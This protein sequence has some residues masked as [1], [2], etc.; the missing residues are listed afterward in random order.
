[1]ASAMVDL[2]QPVSPA[3]PRASP[4]ATSKETSST[5]RRGPEGVW[6]ETDRFRTERSGGSTALPPSLTAVFV[7]GASAR[8]LGSGPGL[9]LEEL[10]PEESGRSAKFLLDPEEL[11]VFCYA[12]RAARRTGLDLAG[13][14]GDREVGNERIL[15]L[16]GAM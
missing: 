12:I 7:D 13:V 2:P 9:G 15:R 10:G 4:A 11:V 8:I 14:A 6:Y 1:M 3:R 5:A 16:T